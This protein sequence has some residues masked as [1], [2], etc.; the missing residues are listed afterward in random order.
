[1]NENVPTQIMLK[2]KTVDAVVQYLSQRPYAES[3]ALI[4][5]IQQEASEYIVRLNVTTEDAP[6]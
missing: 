3:A 2:T 5:G 1:M 6:E 4:H